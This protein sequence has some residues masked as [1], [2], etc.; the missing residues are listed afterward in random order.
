[1]IE[2]TGPIKNKQL[3]NEALV[4]V[5]FLCREVKLMCDEMRKEAKVREDLCSSIIAFSRT[6]DLINDPSLDPKVKGTLATG[7]PDCKMQAKLPKKGS[8]EYLAFCEFL[9]IPKDI[10]EK[11]VVKPDWNEVTNFVTE[12]LG[13]GHSVPPGLGQQYPLYTVTYR[14]LNNG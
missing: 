12:E 4:D 3:P 8:P 7:T 2:V 5:G 1:L 10:A 9:K 13:K 14:R 6:K 11:G